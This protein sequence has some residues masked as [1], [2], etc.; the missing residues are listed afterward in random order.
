MKRMIV[1]LGDQLNLDSQILK[2]VDIEND[3][4][5]MAEV[6]TESTHVWSHKARIL[7]FISAMR[8]FCRTLRARGYWIIYHKLGTHRHTSMSSA[9]QYDLRQ[10]RPE[11]IHLIHPGEY[12]VLEMIKKTATCEG[13]PLVIKKDTHFLIDQETFESWAADVKQLRQ[14]HF[15]RRVRKETAILMDNDQPV[16]GQWNYDK[17]NRNSFPKQGPAILITPRLVKQNNI[18]TMFKNRSKPCLR[19]IRG[20]RTISPGQSHALRQKRSCRI[21][22]IS[23][24]RVSGAIKTPCGQV[25]LSCFTLDYRWR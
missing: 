1:I 24:C 2:D 21:L 20:Q 8:N 10:Y 22:S 9:L 12:R 17:E 19:P 18:P 23:V 25:I 3:C 5:W 11:S 6:P 13:I 16:G 7:L 4:I 15:Y 14:E